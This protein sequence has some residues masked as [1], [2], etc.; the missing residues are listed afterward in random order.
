MATG[1][2]RKEFMTITELAERWRIARPT[3]YDRLRA[4]GL[5]V[6]DFSPRTGRGRKLIPF[7]AVL[8]IENR[9]LRRL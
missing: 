1:L 2:E 4:L 9:Q 5:K 3:V 8:E 6:L 7:G